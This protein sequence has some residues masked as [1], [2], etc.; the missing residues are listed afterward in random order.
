MSVRVVTAALLA[1]AAAAPAAA[2]PENPRLA[3][4]R[5]FA[6]DLGGTPTAKALAGYDLVVVDGDTPAATVKQLRA[7]GSIVL[8][9]LDVSTI[10]PYRS[11]YERAKPYR[12]EYWADW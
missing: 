7:N 6:L 9:Y 10:E 4:V 8:G 11:W 12:L 1:L 3:A 5:T 2:A